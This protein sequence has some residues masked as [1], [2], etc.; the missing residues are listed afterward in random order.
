MIA[1][2]LWRRSVVIVSAA[3]AACISIGCSSNTSDEGTQTRK[4]ASEEAPVCISATV[5]DGSSCTDHASLKMDL[6]ALCEADGRVLT[7]LSNFV[8]CPNGNGV[9]SA[10]YVCCAPSP[11]DPNQNA[12]CIYEALGDGTTCETEAAWEAIAAAHCSA[13]GRFVRGLGVAGDCANGGSSYAKLG[14]CLEPAPPPEP[15]TCSH[16]PMGDGTACADDAAWTTEADAICA[17]E[18]R[19]IAELF[20]AADCPGGTSSFG[21][22]ACC[23]P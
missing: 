13:Q 7:D 10:D 5:G 9:V 14:C 22:L 19:I 4:L 1:F 18:G 3:C 12:D 15:I 21:K 11:A 6:H 2:S 23:N 20:L 17:A 16:H 8:D